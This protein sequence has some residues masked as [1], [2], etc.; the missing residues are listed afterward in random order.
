M[1]GD[2]CRCVAEWRDS[3]GHVGALRTCVRCARINCRTPSRYSLE[4]S[5]L[6]LELTSFAGNRVW[7]PEV[8]C[9][10]VLRL[11]L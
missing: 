3:V 11:A 7:A 10:G 8:G 1:A 6:Y 9:C 4:R 2:G 5:R